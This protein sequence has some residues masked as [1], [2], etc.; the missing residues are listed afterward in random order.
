VST[1]IALLYFSGFSRQLDEARRR[2]G[3]AWSPLI[4]AVADFGAGSAPR[5]Y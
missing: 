5:V 2:E 3:Q 1:A 4:P